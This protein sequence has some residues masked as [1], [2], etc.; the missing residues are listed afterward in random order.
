MLLHSSL[1][2]KTNRWAFN[3]T[4]KKLKDSIHG[5]SPENLPTGKLG[6]T[7]EFRMRAV[8]SNK[9]YRTRLQPIRE[10]EQPKLS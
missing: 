1:I 9:F 8:V 2:C 10:K 6:L 4:Q 7:P 5:S 3:K